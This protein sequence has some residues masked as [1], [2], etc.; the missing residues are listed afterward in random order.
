VYT[1]TPSTSSKCETSAATGLPIDTPD[2]AIAVDCGV[3]FPERPGLGIDLLLPDVTYLRERPGLLRA[4]VLT[5]G[6]EDHIGALPYLL[7]ELEHLPV[8]GTP[9][10]LALLEGKLEEHRVRDRA[11][12]HTA[13]VGEGA[14][15]G[16]FTMRFHRVT[17]S[18]PDGMAVAVDTPFGSILHT[19]DFKIDQTPIDGQH[20]D[21]DVTELPKVGTTEE[22]YFQNLSE[23]AHPIHVHLD[24]FQVL[25]PL[26]QLAVGGRH[27][28]VV[29]NALAEILGHVVRLRDDRVH[30]HSKRDGAWCSKTCGMNFMTAWLCKSGDTYPTFMRRSGSGLLV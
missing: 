25:D 26:S 1:A 18:I 20:F 7:R 17:H 10:T 2:T 6:H 14:S 22:W 28:Q 15:V 12:F 9:F 21:A 3:L 30:N 8:Y 27:R 16:P 5:H 19:G 11:E 23:D 13:I 4:V 24:A 29:F